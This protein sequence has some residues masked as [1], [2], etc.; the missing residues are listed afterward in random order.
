[1]ITLYQNN[2]LLITIAGSIIAAFF[3]Y[4]VLSYFFIGARIAIPI[5]TIMG[6]LIFGLTRYYNGISSDGKETG[7]T[8]SILSSNDLIP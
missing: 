6:V 2:Q 5:S 8:N 7:D 3:V 1:M 4:S